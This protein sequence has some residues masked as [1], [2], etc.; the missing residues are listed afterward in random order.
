MVVMSTTKRKKNVA[1]ISAEE[2]NKL[3]AV[4]DRLLAHAEEADAVAKIVAYHAGFNGSDIVSAKMIGLAGDATRAIAY[5][6][7]RI[8]Y[9][10]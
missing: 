7:T 6:L 2:R 8:T 3:V 1:M 4:I 5:R 10:K 9:R